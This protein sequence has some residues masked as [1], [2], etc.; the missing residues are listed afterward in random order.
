MN[1]ETILRNKGNWVATIRPNATIAD[2]VDML[3]RERIGAIVVSKDGN[4]VGGILSE[5]DIVI[6]LAEQAADLLSRT[7]H[8]VLTCWMAFARYAA[9]QTGRFD[10]E[11]Y[12][13]VVWNIANGHPFATT[14]LKSNL[15]H[16][17]EHVALVLVPIAGLYWLLPDPRL[18]LAIQQVAGL[19]HRSVATV[20]PE[21]PVY[22]AM[23]RSDGNRRSLST[24]PAY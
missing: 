22:T 1:V 18:L 10:L 6:A 15:S 9:F 13:Q 4:S 2:A 20:L 8:P 7:K 11:I 21:R 14:L 16:L 23:A 3:H 12:T 17:A 24:W 19:E 5:R